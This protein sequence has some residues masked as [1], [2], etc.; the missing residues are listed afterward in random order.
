MSDHDVS[1]ALYLR[2][3]D[4]LGIEI[5]ADRPPAGWSIRGSELYVATRPLDEADLIAAGGEG[6]WTGMPEGTTIGH[7]HLHVG[8]LESARAF[9]HRDLGFDVTVW[10]YPG[11]LFLSAGGYHHHL[12]TNTWAGPDA[13][14]PG[15][16]EARLISWDLVLPAESDVTRAIASL[17]GAGHAVIDDD[18]GTSFADPWGT[19]FRLVSSA[20]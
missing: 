2:D 15:D 10:S 17:E 18:G 3:P 7:L 20:A 4:G 6:F 19:R 11:A 14:G 12:G 16:D 8:D 13:R 5:Y 9:Y 1:E